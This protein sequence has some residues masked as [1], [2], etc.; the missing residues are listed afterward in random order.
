MKSSDELPPYYRHMSSAELVEFMRTECAAVGK[1]YKT[2]G[3]AWE[4]KPEDMQEGLLHNILTQ[5]EQLNEI[6]KDPL[7]SHQR[8][9]KGGSWE[10]VRGLIFCHKRECRRI[11]KFCDLSLLKGNQYPVMDIRQKPY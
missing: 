9:L 11:A 8:F 10:D 3:D 5:L 2:Y 4:A 1:G 6:Q 7:D